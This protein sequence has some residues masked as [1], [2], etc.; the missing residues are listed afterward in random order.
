MTTINELLFSGQ[1]FKPEADALK[2]ILRKRFQVPPFS[3]LD[4]KD[5]WWQSRRRAWVRGVKIEGELGR[6]DNLLGK[7]ETTANSDFYNRKDQLERDD[8]RK[9]T[10]KEA[11]EILLSRGIIGVGRKDGQSVHKTSLFDPVLC[12]L[13]YR[14]WCPSGGQVIDPF[15]GGA[16]RG[17]VAVVSGMRY[18]GCDLRQEQIEA[19]K[20]QA[21]RIT[22]D[23][24]PTWVC[25]DALE[26]LADAPGADFIFTCP[27]Y[28]DLEK[29]C[30][31]TRDLSNMNLNEFKSTYREII[32]RAAEK[33]KNNRFACFVVGDYRD[34]DGL[35]CNLPGVTIGAAGRVGLRLYNEAILCTPIASVRIRVK[36]QYIA[37]RKLGKVHQNVLVFVKGDW[38]KANEACGEIEPGEEIDR[39]TIT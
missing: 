17:I 35:L 24:Q 29:Y 25:G 10:T 38:R 1:G 31:D 15:S 23:D 2:G 30:D 9:Y 27:P 4:A 18:W 19:N 37:G 13:A 20:R 7:P 22:P 36:R 33:L 3:V 16:V 26:K 5:G 21:E 39:R 28:G 34:K 8:R 12:E 32:K 14:W 6:K 11:T